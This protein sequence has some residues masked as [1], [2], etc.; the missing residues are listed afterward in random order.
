MDF[1]FTD[2]QRQLR[3][4]VQ[5]WAERSHPFERRRATLAAGGFDA[6]TW[7]ELTA[8]GLPG[9]TVPEAHGGMALGMVAAMVVHEVLGAALLPEPLAQVH[10]ASAVLQRHAA[11]AL[12]AA[13]LPRLAAGELVALAHVERHA[14]HRPEAA[15]TTAR[16]T[17]E[18]WRL[19]GTKHAVPAGDRAAAWLVPARTP[20]GLALFLV[21]RGAPGVSLTPHTTLDGSRAAELALQD[22][23]ATLVADDGA[24][25]LAWA[26]DIGIALACAEGVGVME[27]ALALTVQYLNTRRQFGV[28][29]ASFQALRHRAAD[30][31]LQLELARGMSWYATLRLEAPP[32]PRR[33]ALARAKVQLGQAMR[34]VGQQ[35]VQLHGGI[36]VTDEAEISHCLRRLTQLELTFGDTLHH[37]G[38]VAARMTDDAGVAMEGG[39][40]SPA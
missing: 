34:F 35:A 19:Q 13:W 1:D 21:E 8:L 9:L 2:E 37:L 16:A 38:E 15:T 33:Q 26:V 24:A 7:A 23:P 5:R 18:G 17:A 31:K 22:T 14:R 28:P 36:G 11:P 3:D 6:A 10:I 25:A 39:Q 30:M 12:Q 32:A 29:I 20:A 27:R 40:P 4:A